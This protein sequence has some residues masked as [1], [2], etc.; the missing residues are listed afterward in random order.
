MYN[1][2]VVVLQSDH[3]NDEIGTMCRQ[4]AV[5]TGHESYPPTYELKWWGKVYND[6]SEKSVWF[7]QA[8]A[9]LSSTLL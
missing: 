6:V 7:A 9:T 8:S 2:L 5:G 4:L 3:D 1:I